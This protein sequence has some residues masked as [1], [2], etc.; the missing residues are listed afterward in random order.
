MPLAAGTFEACY[1]VQGTVSFA[2]KSWTSVGGSHPAATGGVKSR[3]VDNRT[4]MDLIEFGL[5][6]AKSELM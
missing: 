4:E 1:E 5:T 3:G 2:G 6:G